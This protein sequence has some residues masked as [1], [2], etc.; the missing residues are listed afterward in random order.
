LIKMI[1]TNYSIIK[2]K[3]HNFAMNLGYM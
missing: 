1:L 2:E 3:T